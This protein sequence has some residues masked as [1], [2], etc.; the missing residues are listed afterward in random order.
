MKDPKKT[1][2]ENQAV[3]AKLK[4]K[5]PKVLDQMFETAHD[6]VFEN[7]DCLTC[8]NCCKTTSP[9]FTDIDIDRIAKHFRIRPS[10]LIDKHL[11]M[12]GDQD[13]VLNS[14]PCTFLMDDNYC[15]IYDVRP[16][17]CREY[18]HTNRK[19]MLM[20]LPKTLA[21]SMICPAVQ[22]MVDK[23]KRIVL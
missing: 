14:A 23:F 16:K 13:Y 17:A 20:L 1:Y 18:P 8:A 6:E 5:K 7:T 11:H 4:N 22:A 10:E 2:K 12:D 15:S 21:N 9:I 3:F 19:N